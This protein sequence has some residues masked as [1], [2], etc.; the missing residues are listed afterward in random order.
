MNELEPKFDQHQKLTD[1]PPS[2]SEENDRRT[3]LFVFKDAGLVERHGYVPLWLKLVSLGLLIWGVYYL[4]AY[5]YP[6]TM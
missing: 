1:P 6:P 4:W 3:D 2:G 5:W